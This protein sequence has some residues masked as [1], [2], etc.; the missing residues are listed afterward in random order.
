MKT[1][2]RDSIGIAVLAGVSLGTPALAA[3]NIGPLAWVGNAGNA[4]DPL[5]G[6]G[7][8]AQDFQ[9]MKYEVT[10]DQYV[11]FL[12]SV[13]K[14]DTNGL[15]SA[16]MGSDVRGGIIQSGVSGSFTYT[17]IT[18]MGNKPVNFVSYYD[19][20]RFTNW[21]HNGQISGL[22]TSATTEDGAYTISGTSVVK[23]AAAKVWIPT[24][25]EWYKAAYYDGVTN[26]YSLYPTQS[27][28]IPALATADA[29]GNV[30]NPGANVANAGSNAVWNGLTGNLT[31][32]GSAGATSFYGTLDQGGNLKEWTSTQKG[33]FRQAH[34]GSFEEPDTSMSNAFRY[35]IL[36]ADDYDHLGFRLVIPEPSSLSLTLLATGVLMFRRKR[37]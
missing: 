12:N 4:N 17:A 24:E 30:S 9:V 6:Y 3:V 34:G 2:I 15:Y 33:L 29:S 36:A 10:N 19:V 23:Q 22:Q 1:R 20:A 11:E 37:V 16:S 7:G 14:T 5:T 28:A 32:V 35:S 18:N 31:T 26:T 25:N 13:A 8:V 21:L 27:N